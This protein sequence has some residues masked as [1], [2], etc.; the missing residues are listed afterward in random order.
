MKCY[1]IEDYIGSCL[2][3]NGGEQADDVVDEV[4]ISRLI[5][6]PAVGYGR[7]LDSSKIR[8]SIAR[9]RHVKQLILTSQE[10]ESEALQPE[11]Y[12]RWHSPT[13]ARID[14]C[15]AFTDL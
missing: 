12:P 14:A 1:Q 9:H 4:L 2:C 15:M 13:G 3:T 7:K 5:V 8:T 11:S 6:C 10:G